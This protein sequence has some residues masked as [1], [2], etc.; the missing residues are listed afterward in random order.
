MSTNVVKLANTEGTIRR[1]VVVA[2]VVLA[3]SVSGTTGCTS[4][5]VRGDQ[6]ME[7][8]NA[9]VAL[10][11]YERAISDGSRDPEVY[12]SAAKAAQRIGAF[13]KAERYY[14]Q[15]LR[16]G[17]GV[18]MARELA[19]FYIQTSNFAQA[20]DVFRYLIRTERDEAALQRLYGN[21]GTAL[22]YAG[23]F[24]EA[25]SYLLLAQQEEPSDPVPYLNLGVLYDRHLRNMPK[26]VRYYECFNEMSNDEGQKRMVHNRLREIETQRG[27]DTSRVNL[28]CG[29]P[30]RAGEPE[31]HDLEEVFDL[32]FS[33]RAPHQQEAVEEVL[34]LDLPLEYEPQGED[35]PGELSLVD[36]DEE[37]PQQDGEAA[38]EIVEGPGE[39]GEEERLEEARQ[40]YQSGRYDE[41][42]GHLERSDEQGELGAEGE[43]LLGRANYGMGRFDEA[44][45][46]LESAIDDRPT[47]EAVSTL[48]STYERLE[49]ADEQRELCERF[50][51]WPDYDEAT[52]D[53]P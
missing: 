25:E 50:D 21:M 14:S 10:E 36:P 13:A 27:V 41:V 1:V 9:D 29:E 20:V 37:P 48:I 22:M 8:G 17:G 52:G 12:R 19:E 33:E 38:P 44:V 46:L 51:E 34:D 30:Y 15:A 53:C 45:D 5:E 39:V 26:A 4:P 31:H 47:P 24:L 28:E 32:D 6:A 7:Q 23:E 2:L 16:Y 18:E 43:E 35:E 40:A 3:L 11:H 49:R 42:A